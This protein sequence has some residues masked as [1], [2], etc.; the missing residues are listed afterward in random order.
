MGSVIVSINGSSVSVVVALDIMLEA[1]VTPLSLVGFI[2]TVPSL[3]VVT[4]DV[5]SVFVEDVVISLV[6][7]IAVVEDVVVVFVVLAVVEDV[8]VVSVVLAVVEDVFISLVFLVVVTV[9]AVVEDVVISLVFVVVVT[10]L[11]VG[12]VAIIVAKT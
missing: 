1:V 7:V 10:V 9:L 2:M 5:N 3:I 12:I 11:V 6:I 4:E 8:V